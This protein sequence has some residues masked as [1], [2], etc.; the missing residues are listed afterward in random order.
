M[1]ALEWLVCRNGSFVSSGSWER[2]GLFSPALVHVGCSAWPV[3]C[4]QRHPIGQES[5]KPPK[6]FAFFFFFKEKY[7]STHRALSCQF[8]RLC[9]QY[10]HRSF[11]FDWV[12]GVRLYPQAALFIVC[13]W[14]SMN[15]SSEL[16]NRNVHCFAFFCSHKVVCISHS[17]TKITQR[18][19]NTNWMLWVFFLLFLST[20]VL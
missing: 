20:P 17:L 11:D 9:L 16:E 19:I 7:D 15:S 5:P 1:C 14:R 2:S 6:L 8:M 18:T 3:V 13:Y 10:R 4:Y 12:H